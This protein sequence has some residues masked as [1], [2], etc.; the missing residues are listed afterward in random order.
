MNVHLSGKSAIVTG[1]SR[2]IGRAIV[3]A[4]A[5]EGARVAALARTSPDLEETVRS[6][7]GRG[8]KVVARV[9]DVT[10]EGQVEEAV[11]FVIEEFGSLDVL[12]NNAGQRQDFSRVD[13][14]SLEDW[15]W[16]IDANLTS[17]FLMSRAAARR[18]LPAGSGS[19]VNVASIAG[20]VAFARIG[21]YCAA[22]SGVIALTKV[23]ATEWAEEGIRVNAVAPGW[24]E[25]PMN[26]ELRTDPNNR[27]ALASITSRAPM[28]R[29]GAPRD[30]ASAV[31]FLAGSTG[32]YVTGE[33]LFVDGGW[34]AI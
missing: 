21:A 33:T 11:A 13:E 24:I 34:V 20:P 22:K 7:E 8:G 18:M 14:L 9:C 17:V 4:L 16:L 28:K 2:G 5:D 25:S 6:A 27:D 12:V 10:D 1:A 30:V 31:L 15:R 23:M 19:I 29:F 32:G 26:V 3:Q